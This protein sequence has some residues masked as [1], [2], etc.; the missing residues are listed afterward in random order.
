[1]GVR[2][3]AL[4]PNLTYKMFKHKYKYWS[5]IGLVVYSFLNIMVLNGDRLYAANLPAEYLFLV[6]S[7][8]C[9]A[10]WFANYLVE[11]Y[12]INRVKGVHPLISQFMLSV[13]AVILIAVLSVLLT[14]TFLGQPFDFIQKNVLLTTGFLFRVNLFLN[15]INAVYFFNTRYREKELEAEKLKTSTIAARYEALNNQVNP[16]FLFNS[17]NTLSTLIHSDTEK[18]DYFLQK[19]S[20]IYRYMLSTRSEE[21]VLLE[22]ELTFLRHYIELLEIRFGSML[23]VNLNVNKTHRAHLVPPTVL[24]LLL[25]N[26]VKHNFFTKKAPVQVAIKSNGK[27]VI[28]ENT[29][30]T[31]EAKESSFGIGLQNISER[32]GFFERSIDVEETEKSFKV[33]IPVIPSDHETTHS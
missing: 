1:M 17:L 24:Q 11:R 25:E 9:A 30:Q 10:L 16:H 23:Q 8:L 18:A 13:F 15:T 7:Y 14:S 26:V 27:G 28:I 32:Y 20:E 21:L 6:I 29:L 31:K 33:C 22:D 4:A 12:V 19:L 2:C 5:V 3:L